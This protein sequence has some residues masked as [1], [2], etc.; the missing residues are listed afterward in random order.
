MS[1]K[2]LCIYTKGNLK[3]ILSPAR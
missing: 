1:R 3:L 2:H